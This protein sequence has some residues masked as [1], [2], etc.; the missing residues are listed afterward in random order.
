MSSRRCTTPERGFEEAL[1]DKRQFYLYF[2][3]V[4]PNIDLIHAIWH[5]YK[6]DIDEDILKFHQSISPFQAHPCGADSL[7]HPIGG[8]ID[9]D[10]FDLYYEP[11]ENYL[12]SIVIVGHPYFLCQFYRSKQEIEGSSGYFERLVNEEQ[13]KLLH[14]K[15][16]KVL[17]K[18]INRLLCSDSGLIM[19]QVIRYLYTI[20]SMY[21]ETKILSATPIA[22]DRDGKLC[23]FE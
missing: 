14:L 22:I 12:Q 9:A 3:I 15:K 10:I 2:S 18:A 16:V 11:R 17:E 8:F 19:D 23:R 20:Y 6:K 1:T 7:F 5:T 4:L 13:I 21:N